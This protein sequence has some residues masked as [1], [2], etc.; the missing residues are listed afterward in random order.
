MQKQGLQPNVIT[1][2]TMICGLARAGNVLEANRL[3]DRFKKSGGIPDSA[4]YNTMI[5][6]LSVSNR[7]MEAYS[8]FEDTRLKGCNVY[9]N[10]CVVLM[11]SLHKAECLEQAAIVG[12]VLKETAK[13]QHASRSM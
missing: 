8:L 5:E 13:A 3:F 6:G 9:P 7:A 4:C 10:T 2:T 1:Y 11:D 12:A